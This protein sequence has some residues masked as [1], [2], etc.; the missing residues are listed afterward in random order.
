MASK[1][2]V[3]QGS[4]ADRP[5]APERRRLSLGHRELG[6]RD[7][8]RPRDLRGPRSRR[9]LPDRPPFHEARADSGAGGPARDPARIGPRS[10]A[11]A[12]RIEVGGQRRG[13]R[14]SVVDE[15]PCRIGLVWVLAQKM[16]LDSTTVVALLKGHRWSTL[17]AEKAC[18]E[19]VLGRA[20]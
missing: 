18:H 10:R 5:A 7:L 12:A 3:R 16:E 11:R 17:Q 8:G 20:R 4:S 1:E 2:P 9:R 19:S 6:D 14:Y 13:S 15:W